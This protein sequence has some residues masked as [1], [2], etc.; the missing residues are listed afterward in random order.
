MRSMFPMPDNP[1]PH[2]MAITVEDSPHALLEL[3]WIREAWQLDAEGPDLPPELADTPAR[4]SSA[5]HHGPS[6]SAPKH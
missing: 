1:W 3:L 4:F 6:A 5:D 2:D